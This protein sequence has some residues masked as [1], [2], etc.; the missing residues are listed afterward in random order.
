MNCDLLLWD[1][2][3]ILNLTVGMHMNGQLMKGQT[4]GNVAR[5]NILS[6]KYFVDWGH[7]F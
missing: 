1:K 4:Q 2:R 3:N 6:N 7:E 5:Q